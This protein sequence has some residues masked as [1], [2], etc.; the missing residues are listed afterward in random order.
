MN[1]PATRLANLPGTNPTPD[2][3]AA[4]SEAPFLTV[5]GVS[6]RLGHTQALREVSLQARADE[7]LVVLGPTGAGKTTLLRAIAGLEQ[8]DSGTIAMAGED[9]TGWDPAR[10][11]VAL[12]FQ[13]FSLY[14]RWTV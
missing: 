1:I 2:E 7:L 12:V 4:A 14:P 13:N 6:K 8:P 5:Q 10:R 11:D 9:V 3:T